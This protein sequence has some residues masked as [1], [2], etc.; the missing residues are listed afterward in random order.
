M[1]KIFIGIII[2]ILLLL[3]FLIKNEKPIEFNNVEL[4]DDNLIANRTYIS[5]Y[6]TIA[7]LGL[8]E[9]GIRGVTVIFR[10]I[11]D[12]KL[13][14]GIDLLAY[15]IGDES[16]YVIYIGN[17]NRTSAIE[18]ISHELIHL[19][20]IRSKRIIKFSKYTVWDGKEYSNDLPYKQ[21]PWEI[22]AFKQGKKLEIKLSEI[23]IK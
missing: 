22:D 1:K 19:D 20:Q 16:Q 4:Y 12:S 23:L 15:I 10:P 13:I 17:L 2:L 6:D 21:R 11:E 7:N 18:V 3:F 9:M 8:N 14:E 5:Y